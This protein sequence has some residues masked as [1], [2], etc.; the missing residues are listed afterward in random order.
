MSCSAWVQPARRGVF[1]TAPAVALTVLVALTV[2]SELPVW[3]VPAILLALAVTRA[4]GLC[5]I[6]VPDAARRRGGHRASA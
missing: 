1:M 6:M 2:G 3:A 5:P 4:G